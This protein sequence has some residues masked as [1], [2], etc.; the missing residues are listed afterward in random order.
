MIAVDMVLFFLM[1]QQL[2]M[3]QG[4]LITKAARRHSDTPHWVGLLWT[5]EQP[6]AGNST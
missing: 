1:A 5:T 4:L 2:L 3:V 6:K